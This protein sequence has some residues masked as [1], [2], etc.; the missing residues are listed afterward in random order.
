M[1][2][3]KVRM[4]IEKK[5]TLRAFADITLDDCFVVNGLR[6]IDGRNGLFVAMPSRKREDGSWADIAHP[7]TSEM[8]QHI[9]ETVLREYEAAG[10]EKPPF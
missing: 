10:D 7:I 5:G 3:T 4:H 8:R 2:V 9:N 6:V 1:K